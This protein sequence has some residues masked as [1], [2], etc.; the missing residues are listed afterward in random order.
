MNEPQIMYK[1]IPRFTRPAGWVN[2][3]PQMAFWGNLGMGCSRKGS[4]FMLNGTIKDLG[5]CSWGI[6]ICQQCTYRSGITPRT[7]CC[8][9]SWH[10][11]D[12]DPNVDVGI[13]SDVNHLDAQAGDLLRTMP[14]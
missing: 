1:S 6:C 5:C 4:R 9:R 13:Y 2:F 3:R 14:G 10:A 11:G 8:W 12:P 7:I